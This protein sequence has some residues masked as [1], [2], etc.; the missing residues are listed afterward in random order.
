MG[1]SG[2]EKG[3]YQFGDAMRVSQVGMLP[4]RMHPLNLR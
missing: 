2:L 3:L 4:R 1:G